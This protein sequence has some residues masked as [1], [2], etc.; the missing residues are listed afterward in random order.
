MPQLLFH[1]KKTV[2]AALRRDVW[3]PYFAVHFPETPAGATAG[4]DA[5]RQLRELSAQRQLSPPDGYLITTAADYEK[6]KK[7][8]GDPLDLRE[9]R[10][11]RKIKLPMIG[12]RLPKKL[13]AKKLMDQKA[14]SVADLALVLGLTRSSIEKAQ[15]RLSITPEELQRRSVKS[16]GKKRV[17]ALRV[18]EDQK[19][20]EIASRQ[21]L[22]NTS[23]VADGKMPLDRNVASQLSIEHDGRVISS[24]RLVRMA[25]IERAQQNG[26]S[27]EGSYR[28]PGPLG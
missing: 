25:D 13:R 9:K 17:R 28:R 5:Y 22:A 6:A 2:P 15:A 12:Q 26:D 16:K 20:K 23:S 21:L 11:A 10:M 1:G 3:R 4:L 8:G 18:E 7:A 19:N 27:G 24:N 14:T